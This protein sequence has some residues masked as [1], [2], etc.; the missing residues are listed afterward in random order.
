MFDTLF[1]LALIVLGFTLLIFVHELGHFLA[2]KW[3][4]IRTQQFAIF[5]GPVLF[6][7]RKGVGFRAGS[8]RDAVRKRVGKAPDE[9]TDEELEAHG[10]GETEYSVRAVPVGGFVKMLGQDDANPAAMS[11]DPRSYN[12][13]PVGK[14]MIV[15]SAGVVMN[16]LLAM[17]LF[18]VVFLVGVK[19]EAPVVG[20]VAVGSPADLAPPLNAELDG[21]KELGLQPGDLVTHVDD[22]AVETFSDLT[23]AAAMAKPGERLRVRVEREGVPEPLYFDLRPEP[24][25]LTGLLDIGVFPASS[26][27]LL[28]RD[29]DGFLTAA[30]ERTKLL[31]QGVR[32]G[33]RLVSAAGTPVSTHEQ[34]EDLVDASG[35]EPIETVWREIDE[36]GRVLGDIRATIVPEPEYQNL[37]FR[38]PL[39]PEEFRK[40]VEP[41]LLGLVPLTRIETVLPDG[42]AR[43]ILEPGDLVLRVDHLPGPRRLQIQD[44]IQSRAGEFVDITVRR[45]EKIL[46][47]EVPVSRRG[48]IGVGL[49]YAYDLNAFAAPLEQLV[50]DQDRVVAPAAD[51]DPIDPDPDPDAADPDAPADPPAPETRPSSV[52]ALHLLPASRLVEVGGRP[53]AN[54]ADIRAALLD[55][56]AAAFADESAEPVRVPVRVELPTIEHPAEELVLTLSPEDVRAL[57]ELGW[58]SGLPSPFFEPLRTTLTAEGDVVRALGMG[59]DRTWNFIVNVY[60]TIDRLVR[61]SVGV[62]QLRGPV[63]IAHLGV[64]IADRGVMYIVF[65]LAMISVNLAVINFLPLP[66][67]DGGLF[68]FLVYEKFTGRPPSIAF[69]NLATILGLALIGGVFLLTFYNDIVRL[70]G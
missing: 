32:L 63:G 12:V 24:S 64:Q 37:V 57:H 69:Q 27:T 36:H 60:L 45:G 56:T 21:V 46:T 14:R 18:V 49:N 26:T 8:T 67:V 29:P 58:Q 33:M 22:R 3:A 44:R 52:A 9:L 11:D 20:P 61:G 7:W 62:E 70:V 68:L 35:G 25:E 38:D 53:T 65:F 55:A 28:D 23:V 48:M 17:A 43:G 66:I 31:V 39:Y 41:G 13:A 15:V 54:W 51:T 16:I 34:F 6:S 40:A 2:A 5:M 59:F 4:G 50:V 42:T 47:L 10:L 19:F 1:N 30:L